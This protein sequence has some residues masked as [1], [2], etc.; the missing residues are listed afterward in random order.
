MIT[1]ITGERSSYP[2]IFEVLKRS[3]EQPL[4]ATVQTAACYNWY[5]GIDLL[6]EARHVDFVRN[7]S[8]DRTNLIRCLNNL[9]QHAFN[10]K[11]SNDDSVRQFMFIE[12]NQLSEA[13]EQYG[14]GSYEYWQALGYLDDLV[15]LLIESIRLDRTLVR[16]DR[17]Q[18]DGE[19]MAMIMLTYTHAA[20]Y[21]TVQQL[22][23]TASHGTQVREYDRQLRDGMQVP[24][25]VLHP[26][27]EQ[28]ARSSSILTMDVYVVV[29]RALLHDH[30]IAI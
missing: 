10:A 14:Y 29:L 30:V 8:S 26:K 28:G 16:S 21:C 27:L 17:S 19:V 5:S 9:T 11:N 6:L 7:S 20:A 2:S 23:V 13:A 3:T 1:P 22:I 25:L 24:V 15:G 18:C 4:D 12:L